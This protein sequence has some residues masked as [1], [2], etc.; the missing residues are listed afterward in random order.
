MKQTQIELLM[1]EQLRQAGIA[2][3]VEF[4]FW[5]GRKWRADFRIGSVLLEVEGGTWIAG[6][7]NRGRGYAQDCEKYSHAAIAG[8]RVIRATTDQVNDGSA[9]RWVAA[10]LEAEASA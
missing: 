1:G 6:A 8:Y 3:E 7:H 5:P 10:A 4:A 9:L 2:F